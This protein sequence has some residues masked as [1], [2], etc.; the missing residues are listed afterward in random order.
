MTKIFPLSVTANQSLDE[1]TS[2][3]RW[4]KHLKEP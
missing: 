2:S 3:N 4:K 1:F